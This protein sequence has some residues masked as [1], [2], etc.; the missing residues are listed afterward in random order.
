M[1]PSQWSHIRVWVNMVGQEDGG[2]QGKKETQSFHNH[3]SYC[4]MWSWLD[5]DSTYYGAA[6]LTIHT[7]IGSCNCCYWP[8]M[9]CLN[10]FLTLFQVNKNSRGE[11]VVA[12]FSS[13]LS[14]GVLRGNSY[15]KSWEIKLR[16]TLDR[17]NERP[18]SLSPSTVLNF[19]IFLFVPWETFC[20]TQTKRV[21]Q[22]KW[23]FPR[24]PLTSCLHSFKSSP[25]NHLVISGP[26]ALL[27]SASK[28]PRAETFFR[29]SFFETLHFRDTSLHCAISPHLGHW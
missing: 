19:I 7:N 1:Y 3:Q 11:I 23:L 25:T 22:W 20:T 28:F 18:R 12:N 26:E 21:V 24:L 6:Q 10:S 16:K 14:L 13:I 27:I 8:I 9:H 29:I 2:E 4:S 15:W 5:V 17:T